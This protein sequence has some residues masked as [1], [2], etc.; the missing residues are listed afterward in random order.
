M[1]VKNVLYI[2]WIGYK[3]LGD[4]LMYDLFKEQ[5]A[6]LGDSF[7]LDCVNI[8]HKYLKNVRIDDFDLIVLGGGSI[9]NGKNNIVHPYIIEYLH[10][11]LLLNKKIMMWGTGIDWLPK[12]YI[13]QL[14]SSEKI[15]L[16]S[17][18]FW[19]SKVQKVFHESVWAGVR[20]PLTFK[21]LEQYGV[22][23]KL[24]I[25]GDS[26]FL[27]NHQ[28]PQKILPEIQ[29]KKTIGVNWG[30]SF[31][32]IYGQDELKVE[33]QLANALNQLIE[34][35]YTIY[36]YTVWQ[37]DYE[38]MDRLYS[39]LNKTENV[40]LDKTLYSHNELLGILKNFTFTINFKLH[41][42]YLSLAANV[43]FIALGYRFKVFDFIKSINLEKYIIA[44]DDVDIDEQ[45]LRLEEDI[46]VNSSTL[47]NKMNNVRE[48][49]YARIIEPFK[50]NLFL[51]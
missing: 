7:K 41:P 14:E 38:A 22:K 21:I 51:E 8:E 26:A 39:K 30:T 37:S 19:K 36:L 40:I 6:T 48:T 10:Q 1:I 29:G 35:D 12:S 34:K 44:T 15:P 47:K 13:Q 28:V 11:C 5:F 4:E 2:G 31:N 46:S 45:I 43:P 50:N 23:D 25:S 24:H 42:N 49:Y 18:D 3:N 32:N 17:T 16:D 33:D 9:L 27:L 20:G